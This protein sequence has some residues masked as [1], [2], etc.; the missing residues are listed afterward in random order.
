MRDGWG[1]DNTCGA[2]ILK[3]D[4]SLAL[5]HTQHFAY[6]LP[7]CSGRTSIKGKYAF[8]VNE[9]LRSDTGTLP[10]LFFQ[11]GTAWWGGFW[12]DGHGGGTIA[13][14]GSGRCERGARLGDGELSH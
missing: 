2:P 11:W 6:L 5:L 4:L 13:D 14:M 1:G 3:P 10:L 7:L 9:L 12:G 8:Q